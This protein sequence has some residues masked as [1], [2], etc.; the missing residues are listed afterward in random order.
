MVEILQHVG[1]KCRHLK[2]EM[3]IQVPIQIGTSAAFWW[4]IIDNMSWH[5]NL[6]EFVF[7]DI[8]NNVLATCI[9]TMQINSF[10]YAVIHI[11]Q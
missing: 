9:S 3:Q 7:A 5:F 11:Y 1:S 8:D 10:A 2:N 6:Y 4:H